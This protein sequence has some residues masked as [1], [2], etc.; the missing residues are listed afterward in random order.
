MNLPADFE[1][2]T[3]H[4]MGE[5][6]FNRFLVSFNAGPSVSIRVNPA[7]CCVPPIESTKVNWCEQ[8]FYL[9]TRPQFTFDPLLH[10]GCYYVQE[11]SSMFLYHILKSVVGENTVRMLDM[12][13]A[14]GGKSTTALSA[15]P[16]GSIL[17]SNEVVRQRANVLAENIQK[18]GNPNVIV[19]NNTPEAYAH[20][21]LTF[22]VVLCDVPCSGEGMFRKDAGAIQE[23][24]RQNVEKCR[25]LQRSIVEDAWQ[26]LA[27]GGLFVYSTC[28]F[29]ALEDEENVEW[30]CSRFDTELLT[31]DIDETWG[32]TGALAGSSQMPVY[33][34]IPGVSRGEGLFIAVFRKR[35]GGD[36]SRK[37][38]RKN[39]GVPN[40]RGVSTACQERAWLTSP[41]DFQVYTVEESVTAIPQ[42]MASLYCHCSSRMKVLHAGVLL[43]KR[44][45]KDIIPDQSLA[46]STSLNT[47][48]FPK[49]ELC[50]DDAISYLRKESIALPETTPRGFVLATYQHMPLGFLKNIGNRANNLY[51]QEWKIKSSHIPT[52]DNK[53]IVFKQ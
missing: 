18:W 15:L 36:S 10:A 2:Y 45:G 12:C 30:I 46:L 28:T 21:G 5:E 7:K 11:A 3:R 1:K 38:H 6:L 48:A 50:Y 39:S 9:S 8:G 51:P 53:P 23:W 13:A 49:V 24:S 33:R 22:D 43:G 44:K 26:C 4:L 40:G 41:T 52:R 14:P 31:V 17:V 37:E 32:I 42:A 16:T 34:F 29:N 25:S 19:T 47:D 20:S 35:G 27:D